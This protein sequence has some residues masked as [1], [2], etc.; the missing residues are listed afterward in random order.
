MFSNNLLPEVFPF[1]CS[2][3]EAHSPGQG[4]ENYSPLTPPIAFVNQVLLD[5]ATLTLLC[6]LYCLY[7]VSMEELSSDNR[8]NR[9]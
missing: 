1:I 2:L 3:D 9:I 5:I 6:N 4:L 7:T 8:V